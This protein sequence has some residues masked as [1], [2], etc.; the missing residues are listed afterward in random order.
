MGMY[1]LSKVE[2]H[3]RD[4]KGS[5]ASF[6]FKRMMVAKTEW[7]RKTAYYTP[8]SILGLDF[9]KDTKSSLFINPEKNLAY[10]EWF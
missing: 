7:R 3:F 1:G 6:D 2:M 10:I 5:I 9:I 4:E 8:T